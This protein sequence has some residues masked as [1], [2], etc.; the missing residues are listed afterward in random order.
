MKP[1]EQYTR[2]HS[3]GCAKFAILILLVSII[4]CNIGLKATNCPSHD[5]HWFTGKMRI[6]NH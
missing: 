2:Y 6:Y 5:P 1:E 4:A 3:S